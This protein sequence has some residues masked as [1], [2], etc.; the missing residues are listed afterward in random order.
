[1]KSLQLMIENV[2]LKNKE[3]LNKE[4]EQK[5]EQID[6]MESNINELKQFIRKYQVNKQKFTWENCKLVRLI[7]HLNESNERYIERNDKINQ[8][9]N[10]IQTLQDD[11]NFIKKDT[12]ETNEMVV[13]EKKNIED[14]KQKIQKTNKAISDVT[15]S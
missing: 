1:M 13:Q 11:L 12:K 3:D 9:V 5:K 7:N 2:L 14:I 6:I 10:D 8:T 15:V 4:I